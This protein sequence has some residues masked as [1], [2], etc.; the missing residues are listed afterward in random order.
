MLGQHAH[1]CGPLPHAGAQVEPQPI[2]GHYHYVW[3]GQRFPLMNG[4]SILSCLRHCPSAR[5]TL[6]HSDDLDHDLEFR[7]LLQRGVEAKRLSLETVLSPLRERATPFDVDQLERI[8]RS[9]ESHVTRSNLVRAALLYRWGGVY[10]DTD[11]LV[12]RDLEPL[13]SHEA[14]LGSEHIL[15]PDGAHRGLGWHRLV[16][17]PVLDAL[18]HC[19]ARAPSGVQLYRRVQGWYPRAVNGAILGARPEHPAVA[20]L[21]FETTQVPQAEWGIKHRLGTH[22]LQ[23]TLAQYAASDLEVV[24]PDVFYPLGP[25]WSRQYFR[26]CSNPRAVAERIVTP[27]TRVLHWYAS[28]TDLARL[29]PRELSALAERTAFGQLC[30]QYLE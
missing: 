24:A 18:R 27:S 17:G 26:P 25:E 10:L 6:W 30:T 23:R 15:W 28:V 29:G 19:G 21:L 5:V 20:R 9:V 14:F 12:V 13:R 11:T 8:W 16:R 4:I 1:V 3:F 2:P 7:R 22:V